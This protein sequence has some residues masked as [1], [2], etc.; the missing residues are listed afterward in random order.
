MSSGIASVTDCAVNKQSH[1]SRDESR[2]IPVVHHSQTEDPRENLHIS[3][4]LSLS[5]GERRIIPAARWCLQA[6]S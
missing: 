6:V 5:L 2:L 4:S 1:Q 3:L